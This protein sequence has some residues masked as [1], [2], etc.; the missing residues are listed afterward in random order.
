MSR[1]EPRNKKRRARKRKRIIRSA[2]VLV[3]LV[4]FAV[5]GF[6][7]EARKKAVVKNA[8]SYGEALLNKTEKLISE[9]DGKKGEEE[10][11]TSAESEESEEAQEENKEKESSEEPP[12]KSETVYALADAE[13]TVKEVTVTEVL[14]AGEGEEI[15][16]RSDLD[17]IKNVNGDEEYTVQSDGSISWENLG[18]NIQYEGN[19][20]QELPISVKISYYL[21]GEKITPEEIAGKSGKVTVRYDYENKTQKTVTVGEESY[22]VKVPFVVTTLVFLD[23][24]GWSD[25]KVTN[26]K[27]IDLN[28]ESA[29]VGYALPGLSQCL[30]LEE[31]EATE[32]IELPEY[33]EFSATVEDFS[34]EFSA[35]VA[36][37][38]LFS[39]ID[40]ED[41][42]SGEDLAEAM[43]EL[44]DASDQ[45]VDGSA[46]LL[47][48]MEQFGG[49]LSQYVNGVNT[50]TANLK[51]LGDSLE[52]LN[53]NKD[54]LEKGAKDLENGLAQINELLNKIEIPELDQTE[55]LND[56][57]QAVKALLKEAETLKEELAALKN[58][59]GQLESFL[60]EAE[61]YK[62]AVESA[63]N[64]IR[65]ALSE[66]GSEAAAG[67][68]NEAAREQVRNALSDI[69]SETELSEEEKSQII[70]N[71][72]GSID[73]SSEVENAQQNANENIS[74][75]LEA[76][77]QIPELTI[78]ETSLDSEEVQNKIEEMQNQLDLLLGLED[79]L[80][81][82]MIEEL[83]NLK[84]DFENFKQ[85]ISALH[86]GS[87]GLS[88]GVETYTQ[89]IGKLYEGITEFSNNSG[90]ISQAGNML[91]SGY[92]TI[93][94]GAGALSEGMSAFDEEGIKKMGDLAGDDLVRMLNRI[95]ALKKADEEYNNY[96]GIGEGQT[97]SVKF[98]IETEEIKK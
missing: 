53:E 4:L 78:P 65:E 87:E 48:G 28:G 90:T 30:K 96:G 73:V 32:D 21:D 24:E 60:K 79:L 26:G 66:A 94:S 43:E 40:E 23:S 59:I 71:A 36:T 68:I 55:E 31:F 14:Q 37:P 16:D 47:G 25:L 22:D 89:A 82:D 49:Y 63:C 10:S 6:Q 2:L 38:G 85:A 70:E 42:E 64:D 9:A 62:S 44:N 61:A 15:P 13:G 67:Q 95:R 97:G 1:F 34:M 88:G 20:S 35:T 51:V 50:I 5:W 86:E 8:V 17:D 29:V 12:D 80:S 18:Q 45:L 81:D 57:D 74:K 91:E 19:S 33:M 93:V 92:S 7:P 56:A 52:Q 27:I 3:I 77:D 69:L 98:I 58:Q 72:A 75:A 83:A 84:E 11:E 46:A 41:L 54:S 39:E 76:L